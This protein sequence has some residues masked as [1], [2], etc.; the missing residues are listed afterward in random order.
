METVAGNADKL[1][2]ELAV[3]EAGDLAADLASDGEV[4]FGVVENFLTICL[5]PILAAVEASLTIPH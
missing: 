5:I 1:A 2:A 3:D 4:G